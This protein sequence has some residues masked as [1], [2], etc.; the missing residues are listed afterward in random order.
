MPTIN[1]IVS[2]PSRIGSPSCPPTTGNWRI[3]EHLLLQP[4]VAGEHEAEH[5]GQ[6]QQEREQS[7]EGE[8]G[9]EPRRVGART[10]RNTCRALPAGTAPACRR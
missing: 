10:P 4:R 6:E 2:P 8:V 1:P 5:G 3:G 9:D 7:H